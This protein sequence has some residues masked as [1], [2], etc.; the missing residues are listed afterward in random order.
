MSMNFADLHIHSIYSDGVLS[1]NQIIDFAIKNGI[2]CISITDH[3]TVAALSFIQKSYKD[4]IIVPGI[5]LSC[6]YNE[7][8]IHIL[9]YFIDIKSKILLNKIDKIQEGRKERVKEII[10]KLNQ[11]NI[12]LDKFNMDKLGALGRGNI[13]RELFKKGYAGSPKQ[14]FCKFLDIGKMAYVPNRKLNYKEAIDLIHMCQGMA[15]LAHPGKIHRNMG[16]ETMIKELKISGIDGIEVY[17]SSHSNYQISNFYNLSKK[18]KLIITGGSDFHYIEN[19]TISIGS[20]G[21]NEELYNKII[22]YMF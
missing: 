22:K 4:L 13:A 6:V 1:P 17:H 15:V 21:I 16:L 8:Q 19:G 7:E 14:A 5:E 9:G 2:R 18:Y 10:E 3:D 20:K 11:N 12:F